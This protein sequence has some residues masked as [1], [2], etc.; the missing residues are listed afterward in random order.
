MLVTIP[1]MIDPGMR[2]F[3]VR[4]YGVSPDA[5]ALTAVPLRGGLSSA[6]ERVG[7]RFLDP[8][9][10]P[11][12]ARFI[13]KTVSGAELREI[14][15]YESLNRLGTALAPQ[16][17]GWDRLP[18][19]AARLYLEWVQ[20][21]RSWPW[22]D[23]ALVASVLDRLAY[24]HE[25]LPHSS[26]APELHQWDYEA[27]LQHSAEETLEYFERVLMDPQH[28][29]FKRFLAPMRRV[30]VWLGRLRRALLAEPAVIHGDAHTGNVMVRL[31]RSR[32]MPILLDWARVRVGSPLED[33]NSWLQSLGFW[34]FETH[35]R[36]DTLLRRYLAAR[37]RTGHLGTTLRDA[38]AV[39]RASNAL[40]GAMR[41]HLTNMADPAMP[42]PDRWQAAAYVH[43]WGRGII[44]AA[45]CCR[46]V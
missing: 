26:L 25:S 14:A 32:R 45:A 16:L 38:Y 8:A 4:H 24:L 44:R 27:E 35:R 46:A 37:G 29:P 41:Y 42:D 43:D 19:G 40:A 6:V 10:R 23:E 33:V 3:A 7:V 15:A 17:L 39:A 2:A 36:H 20:S 30:I 28:R 31:H 11:R 34:E 18:G 21:W 1:L 13:A 9:H 5:F 22:T 12:T